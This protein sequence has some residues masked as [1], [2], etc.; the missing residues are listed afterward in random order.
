MRWPLKPVLPKEIA[1]GGGW[2]E[3]HAAVVDGVR[4]ALDDIEYF[5]LN[6][7]WQGAADAWY[8]IN[9]AIAGSFS[10]IL[11]RYGR[12]AKPGAHR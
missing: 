3:N 12:H 6:F 1:L 7:G 2:D 4:H 5:R 10:S 9:G 8:D 11:C